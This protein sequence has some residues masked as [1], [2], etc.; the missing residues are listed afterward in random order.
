M[1][2]FDLNTINNIAV[3]PD[4]KATVDT[5]FYLFQFFHV[6][7]NKDFFIQLTPSNPS[8]L[9]YK[10]FSLELPTDLDIPSGKG[11]YYIWQNL[12]D[13]NLDPDGLVELENGK[14]TVDPE[15]DN[16]FKFNAND[17]QDYKFKV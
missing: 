4:E 10:K 11:H 15:A 16:N 12:V 1:L 9:R 2:I 8:S 5:F 13:G 17:E 7:L 14:F 6:Q 3:T